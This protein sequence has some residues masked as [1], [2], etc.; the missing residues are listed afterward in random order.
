MRWLPRIRMLLARRP[1][2]YWLL[3]GLIGVCVVAAVAAA[4]ADVRRQRDSWGQA[5]TVLV[6]TRDVAVGEPLAGAVT[7]RDVPRAVLPPSALTTLSPDATATQ[8]VA[9]GEIVVHVDVANERGPLALVP[10]GWLAIDV[11]RP[12]HALDTARPLFEIGDSAVVLADGSIIA[13]DAIIV[14]VA[15][16]GLAV[17][18]PREVAARVA[19]A[20]NQRVAVLALGRR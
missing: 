4:M 10:S 18:V 19:Q 13:D 2:L 5:A 3:V 15:V 7:S 6:A 9:A 17:A 16:D 8:Q 1:W 14:D 20:A 12:D 11:P